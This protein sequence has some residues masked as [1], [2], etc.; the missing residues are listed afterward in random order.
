MAFTQADADRL[1]QAIAKGA[2]RL[3]LNGEK[4]EFRSL[5]E[6]KETL[7]MIEAE[8]AGPFSPAFGINY[9]RTTRGL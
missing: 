3:E 7:R 4:V 1:R 9:P 5:A 6:M 2:S 8:L